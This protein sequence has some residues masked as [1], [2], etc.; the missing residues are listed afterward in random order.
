MQIEH[1]IGVARQAHQHATHA[2]QLGERRICIGGIEPIELAQHR[3]AHH[4]RV[5]IGVARQF[6]V[7]TCRNGRIHR[8]IVAIEIFAAG[9]FETA[10]LAVQKRLRKAER[11]GHRHDDNLAGDFSRRFKGCESRAQMMRHQH[12]RQF[13]GVQRGLDIDFLARV[14]VAIVKADDFAFCAYVG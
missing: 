5:R 13:I 4:A 3:F 11:I 2:R 12:A 6:R 9:Q 14:C 8:R 10:L 7:D 1:D